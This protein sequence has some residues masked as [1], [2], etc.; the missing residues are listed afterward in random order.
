[1]IM[2]IMNEW[3]IGGGEES[4]GDSGGG[5]LSGVGRIIHTDQKQQTL[6]WNSLLFISIF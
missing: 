4:S 6:D 3:E 1:M 2:L 5:F